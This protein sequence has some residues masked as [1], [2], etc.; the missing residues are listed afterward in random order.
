MTQFILQS[1][2]LKANVNRENSLWVLLT[3]ECIEL[4]LYWK[5]IKRNIMYSIV[6]LFF[7]LLEGLL[8][9]K[10]GWMALLWSTIGFLFSLYVS[11]NIV[12][13]LLLGIPMASSH[14]SKNEMRPAVYF[15]LI[16]AP[17][18]WLGLFFILGWI[19][20]SIIDW[21]S[22]NET[23]SIGIAFGFL[24]ILFSPL[25]KKTRKDFRSDFDK[26]YGRYYI[27]QNNLQIKYIDPSDKTKLKQVG[28]VVQI[29]S[30]LYYHDFVTSFDVLKLQFPDSRFRCLVLSLSATLKSCDDLFESLELQ[31]KA[32]LSFL[33]DFANSKENQQDFFSTTTTPEQADKSAA[34]YLNEYAKNWKQYDEC[35]AKGDTK[36]A[37]NIL[38]QMIHSVED[39]KHLIESDKE[40]LGQ[41]CW[42]IEFSLTNETMREAFISLISK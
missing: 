36:N 42:Q 4:G 19:F 21:L 34:T 23:L 5:N 24:A 16:R 27:T 15:A 28:A 20:P 30:N 3:S 10:F 31:R 8:I 18:I 11:A 1:L 39:D 14:I 32:C 17:F 12:L 26:S 13:P 22:K 38:M 33:T 6:G 2:F 9:A 40:R 25:S 41:L 7:C 37:T 29:A 35:L